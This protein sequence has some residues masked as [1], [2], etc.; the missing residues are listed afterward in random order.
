MVE[1]EESPLSLTIMGRVDQ[2]DKQYTASKGEGK[3]DK[4]SY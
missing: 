3:A 4:K 2:N 1:K